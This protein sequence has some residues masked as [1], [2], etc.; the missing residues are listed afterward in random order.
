MT[1]KTVLIGASVIALIGAAA[2]YA[3][4]S[5]S[6][7]AST[8]HSEA[9]HTHDDGG[10]HDHEGEHQSQD[11]DHDDHGSETEGE[12]ELTSQQIREAAIVI[13]SVQQ[14]ATASLVLPATVAARPD[15]I[16]EIDARASGIV[17]DVRKT[18]GDPVEKGE[19]IARLESAQAATLAAAQSTAQARLIQQQ[20]LYDRERRLFEQNVT[21]RE[22][23]EAAQANLDIARSELSRAEAAAQAAGVDADGRS[24][25]VISPLSGR[26]TAAKIAL[27]SYVNA[28]AELYRAVDPN[29][30]QIEVAVPA[31]DIARLQLGDL[32]T[33]KVPRGLSM[34]A[35]IR[36]I[37]PSLDVEN[38]TAIA[39]LPLPSGTFNLQPGSFLSVRLQLSGETDSNLVVVPEDAV[40]TID[41]E[42]VVFVRTDHGF[43]MQRVRTGGRSAGQVT[44]LSGLQ[45]GQQ[46]AAK[47]AFLLKGE[48]EK[49]EAGHGH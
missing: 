10:P 21:A 48:L 9:E 6:E 32:A 38:R 2:F 41:G 45:P 47:N 11:G 36:S 24:V 35:K 14:G 20:A 7:N 25:A 27:G 12:V 46:I 37:T 28:G 29:G 39:V 49:E 17:T 40:Q 23:L 33:F 18:L 16:A 1:R 15:S 22:E 8:P 3:L 5:S 44:I 26:I 31:S 30:L 43:L 4:F 42:T 19:I 13:A 34:S